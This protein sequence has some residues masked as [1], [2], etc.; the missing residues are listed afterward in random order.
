MKF[1]N[2]SG[3]SMLRSWIWICLAYLSVSFCS[4]GLRAGEATCISPQ[5]AQSLFSL[6]TAE[7]SERLLL[8]ETR[9]G[10]RWVSPNRLVTQVLGLKQIPNLVFDAEQLRFLPYTLPGSHVLLVTKA[11]TLS[12]SQIEKV[13]AVAKQFAIKISLLTIEVPSKDIIDF[14]LASGGSLWD[15]RSVLRQTC[16]G[17]P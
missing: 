15:S 2:E 12:R 16:A 4:D 3:C 8:I 13:I 6:V 14:I 10:S 5:Q 7:Q 1:K 11:V 9:Y 17:E